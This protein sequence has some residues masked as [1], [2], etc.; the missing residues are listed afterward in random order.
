[1]SNIS[2]ISKGNNFYVFATPDMIAGQLSRDQPKTTA[3]ST[4]GE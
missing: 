3:T 2:T 4:I 1:M